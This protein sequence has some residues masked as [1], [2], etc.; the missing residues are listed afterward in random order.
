MQYAAGFHCLGC[1]L[2]PGNCCYLSGVS[3]GMAAVGWAS[4][5]ALLPVLLGQLAAHG[6]DR[7]F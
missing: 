1:T 7:I 2:T 3:Q 6:Q 5:T 4:S